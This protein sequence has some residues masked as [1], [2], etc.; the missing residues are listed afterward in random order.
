M[1]ETQI[2][3]LQA[4]LAERFGFAEFR[5]GQREAI[6]ALLQQRRLLCIQPTGHGKSL[7][8]QL[9]ALLVDGLTLVIS[10]LLALMRDQIQQLETRFEISAASINSD[11]SPEE[12]AAAQAAATAGRLRILFIAPEKLD[13]LQTYQWLQTLSV[14]LLVVDEAHCISTWGH[15]FR[16]AY[17]LIVAA[18]AD[19]SRRNPGLRLLG[20]TATAN[21]RTEAD[22]ALQLAGDGAPLHVMRAAMDRP[23]LRLSVAQVDGVAGK[24]AT[25]ADLLPRLG[26]HG[27][28]YCATRE[29][30]EIV[31]E[32]LGGQGHHVVA[33][34]AGYTPE[35]KRALQDAFMAGTYRAI[36]AT[37]A[38][39]M[40]IDKADLRFIVHVDMPGSITAYYQEVGRAGRDGLPADGVLLFDPADRRVQEYFIQSAQPSAED[41]ATVLRA[42]AP[43]RQGDAPGLQQVRASTG[44]H[45]TRVT[46]ILAELVEQGVVVKALQGGRQ[47]YV[48][49]RHAGEPDLSRY[50]RQREVR[51]AELAAMLAYGAGS[52]ACYMQTL[53]RALGD[54]DAAPCGRCG[55]CVPRG[56]AP[57]PEAQVATAAAGWLLSRPVQLSGSKRPPLSPGLAV[58]DG[59]LRTPLFGQFMRGRAN[60][61]AS[62]LP[63]ELPELLRSAARRLAGEH[64]FGGVVA[65][66]SRTWADRPVVA[67]LVAD[68]ARRAP[69]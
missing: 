35:R 12:N 54:L 52:G 32:F 34:H 15:D 65:V 11:Q 69:A 39:G 26:D 24:L 37:N 20:L 14:G 9:P 42:L 2:P 36:A 68:S 17:R 38:L 55:A 50:V 30:T 64:A 41:F 16:P 53:R 18:V 47:R 67:A 4:L 46:V 58:L 45:P 6:E 57:Q 8:Y 29:Q 27:I 56:L 28:L 49:Q 1:T 61:E 44:L 22:I 66:P 51:E 31:A 3:D 63:G 33:Y 13:N 48:L 19:L 23:N 21:G 43:D 25:L 62:G 60:G 10:P 5:P 40:G 59:Q 7:L